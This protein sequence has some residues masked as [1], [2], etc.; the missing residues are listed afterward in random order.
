MGKYI[1]IGGITVAV[2]ILIT[3]VLISFL[4]DKT[5]KMS[6]ETIGPE[7]TQTPIK[8]ESVKVSL[9]SGSCELKG[10]VIG[11]PEGFYT[12]EAISMG[13]VRL[14]LSISSLFSDTII[15]EEVLVDGAEITYES[16]IKGSN[17]KTIMKNIESGADMKTVEVRDHSTTDEAPESAGTNMMIN[18]LVFKN[19]KIHI[20]SKMLKGGDEND[21]A[22][23]IESNDIGTESGSSSK[24]LIN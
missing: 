23:V 3:V 10:L 24:L 7:I 16:S 8:L 19:G 2:L 13:H 9:F 18:N 5:I 4:L 15:I 20:S 21:T 12:S 1:K 17:I 11:N 6:V 22:S 14:D